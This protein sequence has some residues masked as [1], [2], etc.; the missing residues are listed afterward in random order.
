MRV[1]IRP[2]GSFS[3]VVDS[4][5]GQPEA[6]VLLY[7][8][9]GK[10]GG[11]LLVRDRR[12]VREAA[13]VQFAAVPVGVAVGDYRAP[14]AL[15]SEPD[16]AAPAPRDRDGEGSAVITYTGD[17]ENGFGFEVAQVLVSH[18]DAP[19]AAGRGGCG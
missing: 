19:G 7:Q 9:P 14:P 12:G 8:E 13:A 16:D 18:V 3:L 2:L 4:P 5:R 1:D 11:G 6:G 10:L 15:V 17:V